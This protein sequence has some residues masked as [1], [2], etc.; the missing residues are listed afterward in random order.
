MKTFR[1]GI[2]LLVAFFSTLS[3]QQ[4]APPINGFLDVPWGTSVDDAKK[5]FPKRSGARLD[6]FKSSEQELRFSGGKFAGHRINDFTLYFSGGRFCK[7]HTRL[8]R[9]SVGHE[10]EFATLKTMLVEK[11]G[12]SEQDDAGGTRRTLDWHVTIGDEKIHMSLS[13][14]PKGEGALVVYSNDRVKDEAKPVAPV[15]LKAK[16]GSLQKPI[17]VE[18]GAK[19]DL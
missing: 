3:A 17:K 4:P 11:Y 10:A 18:E 7:V 8:E 19:K 5:L 15:A 13:A 9:K 1:L 16:P 6:R 2:I 12:P 14:D